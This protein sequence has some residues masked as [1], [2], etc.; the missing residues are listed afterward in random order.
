MKEYE[1]FNFAC[2]MENIM[3][4][5]NTK[6]FHRINP[7]LIEA[8][9]NIVCAYVTDCFKAEKA[10]TVRILFIFFSILRHRIVFIHVLFLY[11]GHFG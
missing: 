10:C 3:S 8:F 6:K 9:F 11:K 1:S 7:Q 5:C 4:P 2:L